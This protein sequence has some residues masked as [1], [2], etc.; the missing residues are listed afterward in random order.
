MLAQTRSYE[1][2][3]LHSGSIKRFVAAPGFGFG[4][5]RSG[6]VRQYYLELPDAPPVPL[7]RVPSATE[8]SFT[9]TSISR[10]DAKLLHAST[11]RD[12]FARQRFGN[13]LDGIDRV[14]GFQSH[15]ITTLPTESQPTSSKWTITRLQLVSLLKSGGPKVYI[16][17]NLPTMEELRKD[18]IVRTRELDEFEAAALKRLRGGEEVV[19]NNGPR[20]IHMFGSLRATNTC[21][22]CHTVE[23]DELLGA[24]TY[25]LSLPRSK[26]KRKREV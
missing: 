13:F 10:P 23:K 16:S 2:K 6:S 18:E 15:R 21:L 4:R 1:L 8:G 26:K 5:I 11:E 25:R 17:D 9:S 7:P 20:D 24:F 14:S 3:R 22:G 12:F 19:V